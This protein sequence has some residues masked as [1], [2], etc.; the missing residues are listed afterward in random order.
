MTGTAPSPAQDTAHDAAP[1]ADGRGLA[2]A[3]EE[4][5]PHLRIASALAG[6]FDRVRD[7][8]ETRTRR[9]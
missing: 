7:A 9:V 5:E 8:C 1:P 6:D 4:A 2:L 3:H